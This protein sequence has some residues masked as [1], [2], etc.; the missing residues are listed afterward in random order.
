M[1]KNG[2]KSLLF[3]PLGFSGKKRLIVALLD[4]IIKT[5]TKHDV[6][7]LECLFKSIDLLQ[8]SLEDRIRQLKLTGRT[9]PDQ[10]TKES[11]APCTAWVMEDQAPWTHL[12][13]EP[14]AMPG[15]ISDEEIK[16]YEY[17]GR[18]YEGRGE[19]IELGPWLGKSTRHIIR[20]LEKNP[21]FAGKRL[22]VFDDFVWRTSW[23]DQHTPEQERLPNHASFRHLFERYVQDVRPRLNVT[24]ARIVDYEG[25][26]ALPRIRW[27]GSP[28][29]MMYID[30]GRTTQV[31]EGWFEIFSPS[32]VPDVSLLI[33]QDWRT[34]RER[35]RQPYNQTLWFTAAHPEL[36]LV[37]EVK[38]GA[39]ATFLYRG[40]A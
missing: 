29:E 21:K 4:D 33:M 16:Y 36:E 17:I 3:K 8:T 32:F 31:N 18:I 15:M 9:V 5:S 22:H 27:E 39:I 28:I 34:H 10:P 1:L 26:E 35:P 6:R 12:E 24:L 2:A 23:M 40:R 38:E 20:G 37:H 19:V 7:F 14:I 30:C 25:N 11:R 13:V